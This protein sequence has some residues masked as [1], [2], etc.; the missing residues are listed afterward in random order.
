MAR[1]TV[2]DD[3]TAHE[4]EREDDVQDAKHREL[5][6]TVPCDETAICTRARPRIVY[7]VRGV[8]SFCLEYAFVSQRGTF[9][10]HRIQRRAK[11]V[12]L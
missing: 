7:I 1:R 10:E 9:D 12:R 11:Y 4:D 8:R 3:F 6:R 5:V 2:A